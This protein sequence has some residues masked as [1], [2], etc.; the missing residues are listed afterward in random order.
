MVE[1]KILPEDR[2][3]VSDATVSVKFS[4][5]QLLKWVASRG[6]TVLPM[7]TY[8]LPQQPEQ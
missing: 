8:L 7:Q 5:K 1:Q 6:K 4:S 2:M 3:Q